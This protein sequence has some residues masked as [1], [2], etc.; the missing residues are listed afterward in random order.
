MIADSALLEEFV[1]RI[2]EL[3]VVAL[4]TEADSLHCY[5]EKMCLIQVSTPHEHV[6]IDPLAGVPIQPFLD[7]LENKRVV[8]HGA[9]YDLRLFRR[10]ARFEPREI[11]DTMIAARLCGFEGLGLA[12]LVER[13]FGVTL[14]KAS[15]KAN[16]AI[17]PLPDQM[18]EY[19]MN[20]TRYLLE[21]AGNLEQTLRDL[22]RWTWFSESIDR[23]VAASREVRE[24]DESTVWRISG[25]TKL[26][27]RAQSIL[28]VLWFWRDSEA[29]SW[30][31]PPFHV[32][33]ND[34]LLKVS[35]RASSN[36]AFSIPR[37]TNRRRRSF[38]VALALAMQV[39]EAEWPRPERKRGRRKSNDEVRR[40]DD[41]KAIRDRVAAE[42]KLDPS[43]VAARGALESIAADIDSPALMRWQRELIGLPPLGSAPA[44]G[45]I[46]ADS[47][48]SSQ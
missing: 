7:A 27:P 11:F 32:M 2:I 24:R 9:D 14:C 19:A 48:D 22:G 33:S 16:W 46:P 1:D 5:F 41:L 39:P 25:S 12:A 47:T 8:F 28:R 26:P 21:I 3:P 34:D 30:N 36:Q 23:M 45:E 40:F 38:E 17:R 4:D 42:L 43:I 29:R 10:V 13:F 37:M 35:E 6:L 20:D 18:V 44:T 31:R 15:Q